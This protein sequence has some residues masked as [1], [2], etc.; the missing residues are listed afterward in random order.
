MKIAL[1]VPCLTSKPAGLAVCIDSLINAFQTK[2]VEIIIIT[3][4]FIN[5]KNCFYD[6]SKINYVE[7][8][9]KQFKFFP[10]ILKKIYRLIW[11]NI[12]LSKILITKNIDNFISMTF[13][14]PLF[15]TKKIRWWC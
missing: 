4:E 8:I 13:E 9:P 2:K 14:A 15:T 7:I 6:E 5:K 11:I 10:R 1:Y 3:E 12:S